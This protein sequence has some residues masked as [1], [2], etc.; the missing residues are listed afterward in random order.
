MTALSFAAIRAIRVSLPFRT[1]IS[2]FQISPGPATRQYPAIPG[3]T[4][5]LAHFLAAYCRLTVRL[6][7]RN[8]FSCRVKSG[9]L[10][11]V[12]AICDRRPRIGAVF[13]SVLTISRF[14][15][16]LNCQRTHLCAK[17]RKNPKFIG[18]ISSFLSDSQPST[19]NFC[20][21]ALP[22]PQ[23]PAPSKLHQMLC[24]SNQSDT[25]NIFLGE[26]GDQALQIRVSTDVFSLDCSN[27]PS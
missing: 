18:S 12:E 15:A 11:A 8:R 26:R 22:P 13:P 1:P 21:G 25:E 2:A 16:Q 17:R 6:L 19:L 24:L 20:G 10:P 27:N 3:N 14:N 7:P 23:Q 9:S 5:T 4:R